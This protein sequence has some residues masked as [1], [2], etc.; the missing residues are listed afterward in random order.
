MAATDEPFTRRL[1]APRQD[2]NDAYSLPANFLEIEVVNPETH[3]IGRGKKYTDYEVKLKTNLPVFKSKESSVRRRYSDFEWLRSELERDSKIMVPPLPGK[4]L[5]RMLPFRG[6]EGIFEEDFIEERRKGLEAFINKIAG[7]PLAQNENC[8]H[9][10]LQHETIDKSYTPG[11][12][13]N[14]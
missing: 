6:D 4:A 10:F 7:H 12:V 3:G 14:V 5:K 9:M 13:R 1:D 11:K 2:L 8:L